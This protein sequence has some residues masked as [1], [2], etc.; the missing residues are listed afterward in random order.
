MTV[1]DAP[2]ITAADAAE[3]LPDGPHDLEFFLDPMCPFAW[4]TSVWMRRVAE[5]RGLSVGWRFISLY[6]I[7]EHDDVDQYPGAGAA[8]T[9]GHQFHRVLDAVRAEHGN[10]PVG[11]LYEAWGKA[12]WYGEPGS[13]TANIAQEI[14]IAALLEAGGLPRELA[15]AVDDDGHDRTIRAETALAFERA[16]GDLGTP[17]ITYDP[18]NGASYFGP[19]IS[20][21]PSDED[22]L[23]IYD[24]LRTLV[25]FPDFAEIKRTKRPPL[26]LPILK[27]RI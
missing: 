23:A 24:A 9:R 21:I 10:D 5:L 7:H 20:S 2:E 17:I 8:R 3:V 12:L 1:T 26:D 16:G 19:V 4:Q 25:A 22:S 18:P 13:A 11:R 27:R 6:V 14:D 15:D